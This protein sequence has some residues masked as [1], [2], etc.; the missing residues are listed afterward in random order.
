MEIKQNLPRGVVLQDSIFVN[1][2][3]VFRAVPGVGTLRELVIIS[4]TNPLISS[5]PQ[6]GKGGRQTR[7]HSVQ[8]RIQT[9]KASDVLHHLCGGRAKLCFD[10]W[11][12][13]SSAVCTRASNKEPVSSSGLPIHNGNPHSWVIQRSCNSKVPL[14]R[15]FLFKTVW[16]SEYRNR[17]SI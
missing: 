8:I 4:N 5:S 2:C 9:H 3:K 10:S 1:I 7:L 15:I 6:P 16:L 11:L 17:L 13:S 14:I 12:G